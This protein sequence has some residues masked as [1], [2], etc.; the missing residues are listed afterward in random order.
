MILV[1]GASGNI[2][3]ELVKRLSAAKAPFRA[4][5]RKPDAAKAARAARVEA[6]VADFADPESMRPA[7]KGV[8]TMFLLSGGDPNQTA[9]EL[10]AVRE[11]READVE[12]VVKLSAWGAETEAFSYARIHRPVERAIE[13]SGMRWTFLRPNGFHQNM[14]NFYAPSIRGQGTFFLPMADARVSYVDVRDVASSAAA[15][16]GARDHQHDEKAYGLSGPEALT[17]AQ[18]ADELSRQVGRTIRYVDVSD[19]DF[20][21]GAVAG[22]VPEAQARNAVELMHFYKQGRASD[23]LGEVQQITGKKPI[24]FRQYVADNLALFR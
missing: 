22:G 2:G 12:R 23:V 21:K 11:A 7:L 19:D 10:A 9:L 8:D 6:V 14:A 17:C 18:L 5:Y 24:S 13:G 3:R 1:T 4:A 20:V 15:I 16:L